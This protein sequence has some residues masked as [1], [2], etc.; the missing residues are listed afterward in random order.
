M[1]AKLPVSED[2]NLMYPKAPPSEDPNSHAFPCPDLGHPNSPSAHNVLSSYPSPTPPYQSP[3]PP[4][5]QGTEVFPMLGSVLRDPKF[6]SNPRDF[7]PQ[8]FLD[9]KGQFKK[10]D[11]FVPFSIG[12]RHC[13]LNTHRGLLY[14]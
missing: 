7:N 10:S 5:N 9:E 12:K 8:H 13:Q 1:S 11:A 4:L 2:M 6:F 3:L 14:L